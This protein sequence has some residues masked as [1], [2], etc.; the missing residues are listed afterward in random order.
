MKSSNFNKYK[1]AVIGC[2]YWGSIITNSLLK[3][4]IK[5]IYIYDQ[6]H[7][8]TLI[9]KKKYKNLIITKSYKDLLNDKTIP[10]FFF[11][12]PPLVN[13][14]IVSKAII[15]NKQIFLEKPGFIKINEFKKINT[16]LDKM[17]KFIMFGYIYCFN[18]Y[19]NYIK[20]IIQSKKLG[21]ILYIRFQRENL[22]PIRADVNSSYDLS[23]HDLSIILHIF[24]KLPKLIKHI[25]YPVLKKNISDISNLHMKLDNTY[26]DINSSWL[27]PI[28]VR[29]ITIVGEKK[30]LFFDELNLNNPLRIYDKYA[31]YPDMSKFDKK[32]INSKAQIYEGNSKSIIINNKS[33]LIN[34][35][36]HFFISMKNKKKPLT[37]NKFSYK[38]INF[39]NR[40][41]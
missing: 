4:G 8:N 26:I 39:L 21:K 35:I 18:N 20:K 12:T 31:K 30:M 27:N 9:L 16:L 33:P 36:N 5:K 19:I 17:K 40:I 7:K 13:F 11:A 37:N 15:K 10:F 28:K 1:V 32:F 6:N 34:E 22:G 23:S 41:N 38:I 24:N 2:G 3:I 14:Q 25:D 29:T